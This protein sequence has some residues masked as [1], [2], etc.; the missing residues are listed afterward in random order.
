MPPS[1]LQDELVRA[2]LVEAL[3]ARFDE[4]VTVR[5]RR[6]RVRQDDGARA[7]DSGQ[8]RSTAG[9]RR[10]G[11]VRTRRRGCRPLVVGDPVGTRCQRRGVAATS[12]GSSA[13][14]APLL[15]STSASSS[16]TCTS[17]RSVSAG[18]QF[19]R[20]LTTRL[21]P[22]A[23]LVLA[24]R[25]PVPIPLA[26]RR[27]AGQVV[28]VGGD[29]L[30]FTDAEVSRARRAARPGPG[31]VRRLGRVAVAGAVGLVSAPGRDAAVP[32]GGDRRR[33]V[34]G[35]AVG[36]ARARRARFGLGRR[37]RPRRRP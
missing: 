35:R 8:R 1:P 19:V 15:R 23:H 30:A 33:V 18:E 32:L 24:S 17:S 28:E 36:S 26:R 14:C 22:H 6:S 20:E 3:A 21:P 13:R 2:R 34:A 12:I 27:A 31:R 7:G 29:A 25:D 10:L 9:Y 4:P 37:G 5:G 11:R 16:T